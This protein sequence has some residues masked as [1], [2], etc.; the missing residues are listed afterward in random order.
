MK[1]VRITLDEALIDR[2]DRHPAVR[3]RGR[4]AVLREAVEEYLELR[5]AEEIARR[6][7]A[8]YLDTSTLDDELEGWA[9]ELH[10]TTLL[11]HGP[12]EEHRE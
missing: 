4:P 6:Y 5:D 3:E 10:L 1:T 2:L 9:G 12:E 8:G 7:R 11:N